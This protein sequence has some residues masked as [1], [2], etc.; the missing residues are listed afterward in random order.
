M[1]TL[2]LLLSS[3]LGALLILLS[4]ESVTCLTRLTSNGQKAFD[5]NISRKF[6]QVSC[7]SSTGA[8][9]TKCTQGKLTFMRFHTKYKKIN[10]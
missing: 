1:T 9:S 10:E 3:A 7:P 6:Q 8:F 4:I 5:S 2:D